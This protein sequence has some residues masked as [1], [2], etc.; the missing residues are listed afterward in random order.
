PRTVATGEWYW[1]TA[2]HT[3]DL[4]RVRETVTWTSEHEYRWDVEFANRSA[5]S[6]SPYTFYPLGIGDASVGL[7]TTAD[8][9]T[10]F[11]TPPGWT[12]SVGTSVEWRTDRD[13]I[14]P[15]EARTFTFYTKPLLVLP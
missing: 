6:G 15:G 1:N 14:M 5:D 9:I 3:A 8:V 12:V 4:I 13:F 7:A 11:E 2:D 10:G